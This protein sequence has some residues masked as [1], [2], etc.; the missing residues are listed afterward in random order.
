MGTKEEQKAKWHSN[1]CKYR[2][3]TLRKKHLQ[4]M[5]HREE[6]LRKKHLQY[7]ENKEEILRKKRSWSQGARYMLFNE[8]GDVVLRGRRKYIFKFLQDKFGGYPIIL[9]LARTGE[10][11]HGYTVDE[12]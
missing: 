12:E 8:N 5:M 3:E 4:Y 10:A 9:H 11:Y 7:V 6:I 1:Y 2:E